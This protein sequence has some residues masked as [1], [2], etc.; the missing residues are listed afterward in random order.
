MSID[1]RVKSPH[2]L[3]KGDKLRRYNE[4]QKKGP[5]F[6]IHVNTDEEELQRQFSPINRFKGSGVRAGIG[7]QTPLFGRTASLLESQRSAL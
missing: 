2:K 6:S 7:K 4:A 1:D 5:D 3:N